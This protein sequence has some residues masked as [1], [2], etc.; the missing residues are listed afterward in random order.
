[1]GTVSRLQKTDPARAARDNN[2][3][4]ESGPFPAHRF[5]YEWKM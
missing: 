5:W 2:L 3:I 1:M 4:R